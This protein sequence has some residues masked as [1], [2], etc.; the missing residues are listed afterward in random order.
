MNIINFSVKTKNLCVFAK[1]KNILHN[2]SVTFPKNKISVIIGPSGSGKTTFLFAIN[3]LTDIFPEI[4]TTGEVYLNLFDEIINISGINSIKLTEIRKKIGLLFQTPNILPRSIRKNIIIPLKYAINLPKSEFDT[5]L[6]ES[7]KDVSLWDEV[8]DRLDEKA[9]N[10]SG[11]QRQRLCLARL[12]ALK[13]EILLLDEPT[14]S[15]DFI[16]TEKIESL[17]LKLKEKYTIIMVSHNLEQALRIADRIYI[18]KEGRFSEEF[19]EKC[20][21]QRDFIKILNELFQ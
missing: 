17:L 19:C 5:A 3:K 16:S 8:K 2:I 14:S 1:N 15:L 20:L 6:E 18:L 21:R 7:L 11:G 9:Q 10:L 13:P 4:S 12:L